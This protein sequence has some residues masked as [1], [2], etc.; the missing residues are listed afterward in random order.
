MCIYTQSRNK[1]ND[2]FKESNGFVKITFV[3]TIK[4]QSF[5]KFL[6]CKYDTKI[7]NRFEKENRKQI[8]ARKTKNSCACGGLRSQEMA[9]SKLSGALGSFLEALRQLADSSLVGPVM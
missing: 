4:Y 7:K 6:F 3:F 8:M 9:F 2:Y 5:S 1:V